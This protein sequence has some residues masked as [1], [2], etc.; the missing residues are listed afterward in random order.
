M[1]KVLIVFGKVILSLILL[2]IAV[3]MFFQILNWYNN[4]HKYSIAMP[5]IVGYF[6]KRDDG[7]TANGI[8]TISAKE[9]DKGKKSAIL[10]F[11]TIN[12]Y[13]KEKYCKEN[14]FRRSG[15]DAVCRYGRSW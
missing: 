12:C 11:G 1:K 8:Y 7:F 13:Y 5:D 14:T 3:F 10:L 6:I 15:G 9:K 4:N 2:L